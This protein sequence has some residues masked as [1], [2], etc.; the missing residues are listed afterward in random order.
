MI[1]AILAVQPMIDMGRNL[2]LSMT[3]VTFPELFYD[4]GHTGNPQVGPAVMRQTFNAGFTSDWDDL[5]DGQSKISTSPQQGGNIMTTI[6]R[7]YLLL[8]VFLSAVA[9][10]IV[11][12]R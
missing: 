8:A 10:L 7:P 1:S 12:A 6:S 5:M 4:R 9:T 11:L 2:I 3:P